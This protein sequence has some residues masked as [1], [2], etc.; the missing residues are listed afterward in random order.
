M[1]GN[2]NVVPASTCDAWCW[3]HAS[4]ETKYYPDPS[5]SAVPDEAIYGPI[6][7]RCEIP[8]P[9]KTMFMTEKGD[10]ES[11]DYIKCNDEGEIV[12]N[13]FEDLYYNSWFWLAILFV[14]MSTTILQCVVY[15]KKSAPVNKSPSDRRLYHADSPP[16][17]RSDS[18]DAADAADLEMVTTDLAKYQ[19]ANLT[20]E[21][22]LGGDDVQVQPVA[23]DDALSS[24]SLK[25][26]DGK[27]NGKTVLRR[28]GKGFGVLLTVCG[29]IVS[30]LTLF[31]L[32]GGEIP[33]WLGQITPICPANHCSD[34]PSFL[35]PI[36]ESDLKAEESTFVMAIASDSQ[37]DWFNGE[38]PTYGKELFPGCCNK[39]D[40]MAACTYKSGRKTNR[41]QVKSLSSMKE[42]DSL[43][44]NGDLTAYFH[45][46]E[47]MWYKDDYHSLPSNI[48]AFYPALGN[49]DYHNNQHGGSF[50]IDNWPMPAESQYSCNAKHAV[51]YVRS[52]VGC[53]TIPKF[54][55]RSLTGFDAGS[56]A[57]SFDRGKFHFVV[58]HFYS[59]YEN[60][61]VNIDT[62]LAWFEKDLMAAKAAGQIVFIITHS[63]QDFTNEFERI[64]I[65][66]GNV[67]AM[68]AGHLHRC[69][70]KRCQFPSKQKNNSG[71]KCRKAYSEHFDH[72]GGL[73]WYLG[74]EGAETWDGHRCRAVG[75][76]GNLG[77][78]PIIWSGSSSFQTFLRLSVNE[79]DIVVDVMSSLGGKATYVAD[80][81]DS[82]KVMYP[83]HQTSDM[84]ITIPVEG[85]WVAEEIDEGGGGEEGGYDDEGTPKVC[86]FQDCAGTCIYESWCTQYFDSCASL[87]VDWANDEYC[88]AGE[89]GVNFNCT[90][91]NFDGGSCEG[92]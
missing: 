27:K 48:K 84:R 24:V 31:E 32:L 64:V 40:D 87:K 61:Q 73:Q 26:Q 46:D 2:N 88:D 22:T 62:S 23:G 56:L 13:R 76:S 4:W 57:Y 45:P 35:R 25:S 70:G 42:V 65:Q 79:T 8:K 1:D 91:Y 29:S 47:F 92:K 55:G 33:W 41:E 78:A 9:D 10:F 52:G 86:S 36:P 51:E 53:N 15:R 44:M 72:N 77:G 50:F 67:K 68:F 14:A 18:S 60:V 6:Y 34:S 66:A 83:Y 75:A 69:V 58:V 38:Y 37:L 80:N 5:N 3:W 74:D 12:A 89:Y 63:A 90:E 19:K 71:D 85:S 49:H 28:C 39:E 82:F 21:T 17:L 7:W 20:A 16:S 59:E 30:G 43:V 81:M 54:D 11:F